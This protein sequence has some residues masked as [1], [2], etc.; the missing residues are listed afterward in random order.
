MNRQAVK[1][2]NIKSVGYD[3]ARQ[4]LEVEFQS[5]QVHEYAKVPAAKHQAL[6]KA[7]S[8]GTYFYAQI[9]TKHRSK[10]IP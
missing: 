7:K 1:S 5:G 9:R 6:L 2:S 10:P 8:I 3:P 4:A